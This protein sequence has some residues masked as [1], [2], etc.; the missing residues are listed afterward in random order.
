[1]AVYASDYD[2]FGFERRQFPATVEPY[3][4][5]ASETQ[6]V[7]LVR[8]SV[9]RVTSVSR[10]AQSR[11]SARYGV[12]QIRKAFFRKISF[13]RMYNTPRGIHW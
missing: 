1:M 13:G 12:R 4:L 3:V 6:L 9:E 8:Q 11:M 7:T 5:S 2:T 10:A